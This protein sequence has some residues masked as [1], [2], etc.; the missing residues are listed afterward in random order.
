MS[1]IIY[2]GYTG[3][4]SVSWVPLLVCFRMSI[5]L[6]RTLILTTEY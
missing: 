6:G 2:L 1:S 4:K 5:E 3:V